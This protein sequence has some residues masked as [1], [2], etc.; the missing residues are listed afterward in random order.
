M[1]DVKIIQENKTERQYEQQLRHILLSHL[2][3]INVLEAVRDCD[4]PDW[5]VGAGAIRNIVWDYLSGYNEPTPIKDVDVAFFDANDLSGAR[6]KAIENELAGRIPGVT[7]DAKNQA[8]VHLWYE[9]VFGYG[10]PPLVSTVDGIG[11]WPETV[12]C[13]GVRSLPDGGLLVAAP[14]GLDDL[15]S[16]TLRRN[17]RR[18]TVEQF[19]KRL[20]EKA[21]EQKWPRVQ[22]VDG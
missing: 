16:M 14:Y 19:R 5:F 11:T 1:S 2:W 6:D 7:W 21:I 4:L 13:V 22:V 15:F 20:V 3:F 18:V 8:A 12:T 10:V 9:A 17:P